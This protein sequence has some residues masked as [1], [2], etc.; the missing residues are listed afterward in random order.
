MSAVGETLAS[1]G[2]LR[3]LTCKEGHGEPCLPSACCLDG[4]GLY[5]SA[6]MMLDCK[7]SQSGISRPEI[8]TQGLGWAD[9]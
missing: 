4:P 5:L 7:G 1:S 8:L 3:P 9:P 2:G 6:Y